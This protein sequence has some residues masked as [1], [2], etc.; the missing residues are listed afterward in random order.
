[1]LR[2]FFAFAVCFGILFWVWYDHYRFFRRY[3]LDDGLTTTLTGVLLFIVLFYVYPM[4]FLFSTLFD[5]LLG[6]GPGQLDRAP[7]GAA[8]DAR[9]RGRLHP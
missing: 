5:Q 8:A 7:A 9:L 6:G 2:G 3:G 1:M 4:K